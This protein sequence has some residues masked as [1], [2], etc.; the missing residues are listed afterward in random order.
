MNVLPPAVF[1]YGTL[2]RG[3]ERERCWPRRPLSVEPATVLARLYDL[4]P[5]P[6]LLPAESQDQDVVLGELWSFAVADMEATLRALDDVEC[7]GVDDVDLYVRRVVACTTLDGAVV[8]AHCYFLA[9]PREAERSRRVRP[10]ARGYC[11]WSRAAPPP[12]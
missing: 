6:A 2:K 10:D 12:A 11:Q 8:G 5:Y 9:D 7:F 3:G 4:G 1:V